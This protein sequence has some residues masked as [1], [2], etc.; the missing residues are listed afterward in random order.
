VSKPESIDII[1]LGWLLRPDL[2]NGAPAEGPIPDEF[3]T[4][5]AAHSAEAYPNAPRVN[6]SAYKSLFKPLPQ[7]PRI[8]PFGIYEMLSSQLANRLDL[9]QY[10]D[11]STRQGCIKAIAWFFTHGLNEFNLLDQLDPVMLAQLDQVPEEL[12]LEGGD[13]PLFQPPTWLM[14]LIWLNSEDLQLRYDLSTRQGQ[15]GLVYWFLFT[16]AYNLKLAPLMHKR[17]KAWLREN[18][19]LNM[20]GAV[21]IPRGALLMWRNRQDLRE[22]F[23]LKTMVGWQHLSNW[24][25]G[26]WRSEPQ[27][28]WLLDAPQ[29]VSFR[30]P[31]QAQKPRPW[32]VNLIGFA[33]D[34]LGIGEDVRMAVAACEAAGIPF[35]VVN[36]HPGLVGVGD[37]A[38]EKHFQTAR[39]ELAPYAINVFCL[40]GFETARVFMEMGPGLFAERYN[41]GWW[42][43]EL[44]VWPAHWALVFDLVDEVWAA[45]R[46]TELMYN[47]AQEQREGDNHPVPVS[48]MPMAATVDRVKHMSRTQLGLPEQACLFLYVFDFNSYLQRKN[49]F[50]ALKA[51]RQAFPARDKSVGLVLKTMNSDPENPVWQ[52]FV[53]ECQQDKRIIILDRTLERGEVLGLIECCDVYVSL[54]RSEGFGRTQAEAIQFGKPVVGTDFSGNTDFLTAETGFPV[55]LKKRVVQEGEYPFV[56]DADKA[57]WADPLVNDAARQ[58]KAA[59]VAAGDPAFADKL[60][61]FASEQFSQERVGAL[62]KQRLEEIVGFRKQ[63]PPQKRGSSRKAPDWPMML[64]IERARMH[65]PTPIDQVQRS[66]RQSICARRGARGRPVPQ[67]WCNATTEKKSVTVGAPVGAQE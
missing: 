43:W 65:A 61:A 58:M 48:L 25:K 5:W 40:T 66:N 16:A 13:D 14:Y 30:D 50:A 63:C 36:F 20:E 11:L 41:I 22:A 45:T 33:R 62:M 64:L 35:S 60:K 57:W 23:D 49:P 39:K 26:A 42:P 52:K 34:E 47:Q 9:Q 24:A 17:W 67:I 44:P 31:E 55:K 1:R 29:K 12:L 51:F 59:R 10:L 7:Y 15:A 21:P 28:N 56:T 46:F 6:P 37:T 18:V 54:H 2:R 19:R 38:L 4:W 27:L 32:G 3:L 53:K 8:G